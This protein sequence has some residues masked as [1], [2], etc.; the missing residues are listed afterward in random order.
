MS[1]PRTSRAATGRGP[2]RRAAMVAWARAL[3][4]VVLVAI[5]HRH[6]GRARDRREIAPC[7]ELGDVHRL[8]GADRGP[9]RSGRRQPVPR[10]AHGR[11]VGG[12]AHRS[13]WPSSWRSPPSSAESRSS[14][15]G[16]SGYSKSVAGGL[17]AT[18]LAVV[19]LPG[20]AAR[21]S[22]CLDLRGCRR[23]EPVDPP[24]TPRRRAPLL[25]PA[26]PGS[27]RHAR[28]GPRR[29]VYVRSSRGDTL[30]DIAGARLGDGAQWRGSPQL[31]Y[32]RDQPD[33]RRLDRSHRL[34]AR[35]GGWSCRRGSIPGRP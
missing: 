22:T 9:H 29:G 15:C 10:G 13:P 35:V 24:C 33:G 32:D 20:A 18:A 5:R 23:P 12:L 6:P 1:G 27:E 2:A 34:A 16:D 17:V 7:I 21:P 28:S 30:W 8:A 3:A 4:L 11:G 26:H 19:L 14:T 25:A 31:N